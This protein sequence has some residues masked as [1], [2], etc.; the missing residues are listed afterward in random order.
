MKEK[1]NKLTVAICCFNAAEFIAELIKRLSSLKSPIPFEILIIDNNSSDNTAQVID[2]CA[3][4]TDIPIHYVH[5]P[6]QGIPHARNRA[7]EES[8]QNRYMAF[9]DADELPGEKWLISAMHGLQEL[10]AECVGGEIS[11]D[12]PHRPEWLSDSLLP[13]LGQVKHGDNPFQIKDRSTPVWSGNVAYRTSIFEEGLRFDARY[14]RKGKGVGGGS[15]GIMFRTLLEGKNIIR[16]EPEMHITHY[17]PDEKLTRRYFLKLHFL[18]GK[19]AGA[20]EMLVD[21]SNYFGIP[22]Y[23]FRQLLEKSFY[24]CRTTISDHSEYMR[25]GMNIAH[26][27]GTMYGLYLQS[28]QGK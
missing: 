8:L 3:Q 11:L 2:H 27:S 4:E 13:F 6:V 10:K 20:F 23:M 9:I 7:I 22:R 18:A 21:K 25:N 1:E 5:E 14:N 15:D 26:L 12:L 28:K 19:K 24:W 17:I 16:Y